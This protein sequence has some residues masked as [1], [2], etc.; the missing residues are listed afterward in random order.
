[1][2]NKELD[3]KNKFYSFDMLM[4]KFNKLMDYDIIYIDDSLTSSFS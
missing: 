3:L 4:I 1:M 2:K